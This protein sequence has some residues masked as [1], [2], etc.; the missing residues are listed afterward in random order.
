MNKGQWK[1]AIVAGLLLTAISVIFYA[2]Q[3]FYTANLQLGKEDKAI[4]IAEKTTF[5]QLLELLKK[6]QI[7]HEVVSFAFVAKVLSYQEH[8]KAGRYIIKK[9]MSNLAAVRMLRAGL[10]APVELTFNNVRL[11]SDFTERVAEEVAFKKDELDK[12]LKDQNF[13]KK[14]GFDTTNIMAMFLPNTY[15]IYW[16]IKPEAFVERMHKEYKKFWNDERLKQAK[17]LNLTPIEVSVLASIVQAETQ[18]QDEKPRVAGVYL[19][20]LRK[21]MRLEADPTL[22]FAAKDFTIKRV[23]DV[24]KKIDSPYN[25]YKYAGLPPGTINMPT[26][27]TLKATLNAE[28][29]DYIF[30]CA[31]ED[32]SGYHNFA[33]NYSDHLK[34]ARIYQRALDVKGIKK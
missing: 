12:L 15:Q 11:M 9:N 6:E 1:I 17:N 16:N 13:V 26:E 27:N 19:N 20:R 34:N 4:F 7:I 5:P 14:Y 29:H 31:K 21:K 25:T 33:V 22:V 32:F 3:L 30:F 23:L 8:V 18:K 2:Y 28:K 10:Q 24:H